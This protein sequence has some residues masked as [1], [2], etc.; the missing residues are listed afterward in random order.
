MNCH[1][2]APIVVYLFEIVHGQFV[3]VLRLLKVIVRFESIQTT[4][5]VMRETETPV[6]G[7]CLEVGDGIV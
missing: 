1:I 7:V 2:G 4:Q 3:M 6:V 5:E